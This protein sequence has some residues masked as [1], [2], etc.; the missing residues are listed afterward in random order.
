M[1]VHFITVGEF[2]SRYLTTNEIDFV[3]K[4]V[5]LICAVTCVRIPLA[6]P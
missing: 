3:E 1:H 5:I 6:R 4:G 2:V